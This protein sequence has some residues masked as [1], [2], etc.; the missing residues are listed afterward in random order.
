MSYNQFQRQLWNPI[1]PYAKVGWKCDFFNSHIW[2]TDLDLTPVSPE[3]N[4]VCSLS[5][6]LGNLKPQYIKTRLYEHT[7]YWCS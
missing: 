4:A 6:M 1:D 2:N 7:I 3:M 5:P